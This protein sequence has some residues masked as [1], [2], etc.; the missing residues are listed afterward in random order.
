MLW[1]FKGVMSNEVVQHLYLDG[2]TKIR[3]LGLLSIA[4]SASLIP[5]FFPH[6]MH[7]H[8]LHMAIHIACIILGSFLSIIGTITY[9]RYKTTR[10]FLMMCA[11]FAITSA[12]VVFAF[13]TLFVFW[14]S[15][16]STDSIVTSGLVL[17]MLV[18]FSAGIFRTD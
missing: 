6:F 9:I 17:L 18:F 7:G 2:K 3:I 11:F 4:M 5:I 15:Y 1:F 10:L 8:G 13:N 12:E 14:A 16:T